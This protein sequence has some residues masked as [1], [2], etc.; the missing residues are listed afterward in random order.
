MKPENFPIWDKNPKR[1]KQNINIEN[2]LLE[3]KEQFCNFYC[4][5]KNEFDY[6]NEFIC[7]S[8]YDPC[9]YCMIDEY[10]KFIRDEL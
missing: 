6:R 5:N 3:L 2:N 4:P 7:E 10:I 8:V 9:D 1:F